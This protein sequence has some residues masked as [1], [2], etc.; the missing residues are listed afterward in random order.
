[1]TAGT[2]RR[3]TTATSGAGRGGEGL[4]PVR[5]SISSSLSWPSRWPVS[6]SDRLGSDVV[7]A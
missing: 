6:A 5:R 3:A 7:E 1:M 2:M 4:V